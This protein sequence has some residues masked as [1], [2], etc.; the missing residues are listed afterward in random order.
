VGLGRRFL[1]LPLLVKEQNTLANPRPT[2]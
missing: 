2:S 1:I